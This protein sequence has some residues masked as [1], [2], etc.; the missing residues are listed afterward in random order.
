MLSKEFDLVSDDGEWEG[1]IVCNIFSHIALTEETKFNVL[2]VRM[3][4][5]EQ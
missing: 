4:L 3:E 1:E 2:H 5:F